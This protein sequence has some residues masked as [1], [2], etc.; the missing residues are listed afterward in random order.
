VVRRRRGRP[1]PEEPERPD[2]EQQ[3]AADPEAVARTIVLQQLTA[4]PRTRGQLAGVLARKGVPEQAALDVLDRFGELGLVDDAAFSRGWVSSRH[5]GRGLA[6][7]ALA[8]E[9]RQRGVD[10]PTISEA[11]GDL[12]GV[13]ELET[14]RRLVA[15]KLPSTRGAPREARFRRLAGMLARKG[16]P[17]GMCAQVV[18]DALRNE[19]TEV[20]V[21]VG[22]DEDLY[23]MDALD[24][25]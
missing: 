16:Y 2:V 14:A 3:A 4:G 24:A 10:E 17:P 7:G 18:A 20:H 6:R 15:K 22:S 13:R 19:G 23:R 12:D 1:G 8:R 9:L 5:E 11:L 21:V 25:D